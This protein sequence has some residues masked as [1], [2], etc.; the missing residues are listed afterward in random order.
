LQDTPLTH[1]PLLAPVTK[2]P[3]RLW[4]EIDAATFLGVQ[5]KALQA[6]RTRGGG[7]PFVKI[8]RLVRYRPSLVEEWVVSQERASTSDPGR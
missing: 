3:A 4:T 8:G 7:P 6:W 2:F 5:P 1:S